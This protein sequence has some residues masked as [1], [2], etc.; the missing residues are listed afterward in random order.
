MDLAI[1]TNIVYTLL[2][3]SDKRITV[4]QGGTRSGKTYN[5]LQ[6]FIIKL[7]SETGKVWTICR[8]SLPSIKGSVL[9][10]FIHILNEMG[11]YTE[12]Y[13]NKTEQVYN[14]NGNLVEFVS[15]DQPQKIRGRKRNYL[16]INEA[17]ELNYDAWMQLSF[18]TT[19]KIVLDYNPSDEYS[20]IYDNVIPR[21]DADF[22]ITTYRDNP[23]LPK[24]LISEIERLE[25]ADENYWNIYGLGQRG[26]S[27]ELI[28]THWM[29]SKGM[30]MRGEQWYGLDF[31]FNVP[32]ALV[33]CEL[34]EGTIYVHE[35]IYE[36]KLTTGQLIERFKM[37]G[38]NK[39]MAIYCDNAEPDRIQ[40]LCNAGYNC[41][42]AE[43]SVNAGIDSIK[44]RP[45]RITQESAN[46][47]KEIRNYK[48]MMDK[49]GKIKNP[50]QPVKFNDHAMDAMRYAIFTKLATPAVNWY[51]Q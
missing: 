42:P 40:E 20:W 22:Y 24:E 41:F 48:W 13:H 18:R 38:M 47:I 5:I 44:S 35:V 27:A 45:L 19:D 34:W 23:F 46:L 7:L 37:I 9:R 51:A 50:E 36:T 32:S 28:Y 15:I 30:P 49:D 6:Y 11:I 14:L 1:E 8:E 33:L 16:F 17:N 2:L 12:A 25:E 39:G 29:V 3:D 26:H 31:G 4:M 10:D 21:K 43:K